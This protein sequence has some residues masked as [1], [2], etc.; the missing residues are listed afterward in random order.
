MLAGTSSGVGKTTI[1]TGLTYA[2]RRRGLKVQPFKCG[3]DYIDPGFLALAADKPS[4]NLDSWMLPAASMLELFI[5][6]S[7]HSDIAIV[8]GVMGLFDG[9]AGGHGAG[10]SAEVASWLKAPVVLVINAAKTA[11]SAAA[12]ALGFQQYDPDVRI[13]GV[14]VN[15]IG[16][17]RHLK[18][19]KEAITERTGLPVLGYLPKNSLITLPERHL[20]LVPTAEAA[21]LEPFLERLGQQIEET[22]DIPSLIELAESAAEI[23][24]PADSAVL[25]KDRIPKKAAIAIARDEAFTFYYQHNFDILE[26][27][28]A[29]IRYFS[30]LN[31][32]SLPPGTQ[33][34]YIG[35]GFPEVFAGRL[36]DNTAMRQ[37]IARAVGAG[38][39]CYAECGGLMYAA[40][41]IADFEGNRFS[42]LGLIPGWVQMQQKMERMGYTE[43]EALRDSVLAKKGR[44]LRGHL[45]H[46]SKLPPPGDE[47]AYKIAE[48][49]EQLEGFIGGPDDNLLASYLHLHFGSDPAL[50]RNFIEACA[51]FKG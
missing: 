9:R 27:W 3:P 44:Q 47:A 28:G 42:M 8:E 6:S 25:P 36:Q 26:A 13:G 31:D 45:F 35:G 46:W 21:D 48:P 1:T 12:T 11:Q 7:R 37:D 24:P 30:P 43:A 51:N 15:N 14:I 38:M 19:V 17:Q 22:L 33:G 41:G 50:A 29:E 4:Y 16:S 18:M 49:T 2:L 10:S 5:H 32:K 20:G 39:P 40:E 23:E 34:I